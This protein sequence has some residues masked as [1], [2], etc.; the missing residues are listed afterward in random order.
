MKPGN[1]D[2]IGEMEMKTYR[3]EI[4]NDDFEI[5]LAENEEEAIE[6]YWNLEDQGH[7][8]FNLFELDDDYNIVKTIMQHMKR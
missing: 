3:A 5:I 4:E 1:N 7:T 6:E 2:F 8:I